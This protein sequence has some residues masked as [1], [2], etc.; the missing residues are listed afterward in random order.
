MLRQSILILF[1]FVAL[2]ATATAAPKESPM[3]ELIANQIELLDLELELFGTP[4]NT[5]IISIASIDVY[6]VEEE[7]TIDF[8]TSKYLPKG[9]NAKA[10]MEDIDWSS[11]ELYE[12]EEE[13]EFDFNVKDYLPKGFDPYKGMNTLASE[14]ICL[15]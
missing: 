13:V 15:F 12:V 11:I 10:G 7:S 3:E 8:D 5:T 1:A 14:G 2:G 4:A 9:F 6:E